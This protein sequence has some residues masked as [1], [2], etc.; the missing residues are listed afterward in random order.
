VS[1]FLF[2]FDFESC[3]KFFKR[4][5]L[6]FFGNAKVFNLKR[7]TFSNFAIFFVGIGEAVFFGVLINPPLLL[8]GLV[9][10]PLYLAVSVR[11][12]KSSFDY[13]KVKLGQSPV[14]KHEGPKASISMFRYLLHKLN[15]NT[16]LPPV[17]PRGMVKYK[18]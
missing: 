3:V 6:F 15:N 14:D 1:Q 12:I 4:Q 9:F 13:F 7:S 11:H 17:F 10:T 8:F 18:A 16:P 5:H 2:L